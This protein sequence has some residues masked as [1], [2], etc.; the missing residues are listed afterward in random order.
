MTP[1]FTT[2]MSG[3]ELPK[4]WQVT[5]MKSYAKGRSVHRV[6]TQMVTDRAAK[7]WNRADERKRYEKIDN[8]I[9]RIAKETKT[10]QRDVRAY[11][12][13]HRAKIFGT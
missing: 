9:R 11:I 2:A 4:P 7:K 5:H 6:W 10:T 13:E 3:V 12:V 1:I 8:L